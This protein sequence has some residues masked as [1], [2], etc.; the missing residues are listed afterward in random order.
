M[1]E[2]NY[3]FKATTASGEV[4]QFYNDGELAADGQYRISSEID[5]LEGN[6]VI[7]WDASICHL[8]PEKFEAVSVGS[9]IKIYYEVP[10]AEYHNLR[11][12]TN[13]WTDVPGGAQIDITADTPNPFEL[14]YTQE[15]K[16]MVM[17]QG[18]MSCVG[19]GYTVKRISYK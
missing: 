8:D 18:G 5:L 9:T 17:E 13:W 19:F 10:A 7:D 1:A 16:N 11:I 6:F 3:S 15:F 12:I 2:G 4:A 14:Q